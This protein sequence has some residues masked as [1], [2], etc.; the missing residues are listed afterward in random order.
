MSA[1]IV[2]LPLRL[3]CSCCGATAEATCECGVA[4]VPPVEFARQ[5]VERSPEKS[6]RAIAE[7]IGVDHKTVAAARR[8]TGENS[9]VR[10][11]KDGKTRRTPQKRGPVPVDIRKVTRDLYSFLARF[12]PQ[13]QKVISERN[14]TEESKNTLF[15]QM[16]SARQCLE[17]LQQALLASPQADPPAKKLPAG[18][19]RL[20]N[21]EEWKLPPAH[22]IDAARRAK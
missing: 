6:D 20:A 19:I 1:D 14:F 3:R 18:V 21:G 7:E 4:Y 13:C 8:A 17:E 9:P 2:T 5:A 10:R 16:G 11:G 22:V 12:V 15:D